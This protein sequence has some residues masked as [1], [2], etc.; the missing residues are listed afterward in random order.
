MTS[1][2]WRDT[3]HKA[4]CPVSLALVEEAL[5]GQVALALILVVAFSGVYQQR[6]DISLCVSIY[7]CDYYV[8][9]SPELV[10]P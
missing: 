6:T 1:R 4:L 5:D 10:D 9:G 7:Y 2:T 8:V 3:V